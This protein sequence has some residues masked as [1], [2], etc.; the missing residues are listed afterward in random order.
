MSLQVEYC[1]DV[2]KITP[3]LQILRECLATDVGRDRL[4]RALQNCDHVRLCSSLS[5]SRAQR[6][7]ERNGFD[8]TSLQ[9][10][11]AIQDGEN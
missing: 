3:I 10:S 5:R 6:F 9:F 11:C 8:R 2:D 4:L 1:D 7:Y